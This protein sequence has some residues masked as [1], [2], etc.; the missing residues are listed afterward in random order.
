[1][2]PLS[3]HALSLLRGAYFG[4][5]IGGFAFLLLWEGGAPRIAFGSPAERRRHVLRNLG[6]LAL[7]VLIADLGV[8]AW[9]LNTSGRIG[10]VSPGLLSR[11]DLGWPA[12]LATGVLTIDLFEYWWHRAC[13]AVPWLWRLHRVHH[14]D[15]HL[16]ATTGARF[17]ALESSL[18][19]ALLVGMM[20]LAGIPLWVE[21]ARTLV[22]N[23]LTL[24]QH[25]NVTFPQWLDRASRPLIATPELHR[26]HHSPMRAEQDSNYGQ[27]F[28][29]WDRL[30]G[31]YR[32]PPAT[33][34]DAGVT[35]LDAERFQ[36]IAG[37]CA[38]PFRRI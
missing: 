8:G 4:T 30:F 3:D 16:D 26:V 1:M 25:A 7:V 6:M 19:I 35:G 20:L 10:A 28:S 15:T 31:T 36:T 14:S 22:V 27:I 33:T 12:L 37:M 23:P 2:G 5:L 32:T 34:A 21:L 13:H 9:L 18:G 24:A 17:H 11:F 29:F 38:T